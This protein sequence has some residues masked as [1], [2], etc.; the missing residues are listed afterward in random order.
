MAQ[1][2]NT[3][4]PP[5]TLPTRSFRF[6]IHGLWPNYKDGT[7]PQ[8]CDKD[9]AFSES[10]IA[11]LEGALDQEWPS[12]GGGNEGFWAHEWDKHGTCALSVVRSEHS[13][14][15]TVLRL[16]WKYDLEVGVGGGFGVFRVLGC[17]F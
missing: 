15:K 7:W 3:V 8:F 5:H 2:Q 9:Y 4:P 10:E 1:L 16:H 6:N 12:F 13:F 17:F 11:D 14:F